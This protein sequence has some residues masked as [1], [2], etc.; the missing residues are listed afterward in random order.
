[1]DLKDRR[2][3]WFACFILQKHLDIAFESVLD[4][5]VIQKGVPNTMALH[6][7]GGKMEISLNMTFFPHFLG[8][9]MSMLLRFV[10]SQME[11]PSSTIF[12]LNLC[13]L[14][15]VLW[16]LCSLVV[17]LG[18]LH[19]LGCFGWLQVSSFSLWNYSYIAILVI[20]ACSCL[21]PFLWSFFF[22]INVAIV[23]DPF[24]FMF[25]F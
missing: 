6:L 21:I 7:L 14:G 16:V 22:K 4:Y 5:T 17:G 11:L 24:F 2:E 13:Q 10:Y 8:R 3:L 23:F 15:I 18:L 9:M 19:S 1:M 25:F 12:I 20:L